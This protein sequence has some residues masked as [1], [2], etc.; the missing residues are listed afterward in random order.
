MLLRSA[1]YNLA[2]LIWAFYFLRPRTESPFERLPGTDVA[3]WNEAL[4]ERLKNGIDANNSV[5]QCL[6]L[7]SGL[8]GASSG[9][10]SDPSL[11]DWEAKKH[12]V[13]PE[14]SACCSIPPRKYLRSSL[15]PPEFRS[16]QR[17]GSGWRCDSLD[18]VGKNAAMLMKLGQLAKRKRIQRWPGKRTN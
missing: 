16:F 10:A 1:A 17:N 2:F 14:F 13:D 3:N 6:V 7:V 15:P 18:L 4:T 9:L 12:E 5:G 8:D 11:E